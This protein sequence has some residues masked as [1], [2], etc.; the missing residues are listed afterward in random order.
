MEQV[1]RK[2]SHQPWDGTKIDKNRKYN[3]KTTQIDAWSKEQ[4]KDIDYGLSTYDLDFFFF[5]LLLLLLLL[6]DGGD[7]G[8]GGGGRGQL[9]E[10]SPRNTFNSVLALSRKGVARH[11]LT[12]RVG[13]V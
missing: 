5:F 12:G 13:V 1:S 10:V 2:R 4:S 9:P 7:G 8:D 6:L 11:P 3:G